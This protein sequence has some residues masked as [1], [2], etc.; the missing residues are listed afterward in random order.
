MISYTHIRVVVTLLAGVLFLL[1]PLASV[2]L[3]QTTRADQLWQSVDKIP[4]APA[5]ARAGIR[6]TK[7]K[8]FTV[9]AATLQ[10]TLAQAPAEF[11]AQARLQRRDLKLRYPSQTALLRASRSKK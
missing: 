10:S 9:N 8:A 6:P 3:A 7:F 2:A 4:A 1:P 11:A 5:N